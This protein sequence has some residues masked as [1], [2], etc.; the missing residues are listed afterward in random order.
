M[1]KV[2]KDGAVSSGAFLDVE[3]EFYKATFE[4][5]YRPA[6]KHGL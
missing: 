1:E 6:E 4:S 5:M 3:G 2:L